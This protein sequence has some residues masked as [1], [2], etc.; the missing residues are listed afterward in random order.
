MTA[1][2]LGQYYR[3]DGDTL[4]RV[5]KEHLS[6]YYSW[7]D[8]PHADKYL[9]FP[10]NFGPRMS[11]DETSTKDGKSSLYSQIKRDIVK[12]EA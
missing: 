11:I 1:R 12:K 9:L 8:R 7:E 2:S 10:E 4:E 5:Y 3:I 6:G